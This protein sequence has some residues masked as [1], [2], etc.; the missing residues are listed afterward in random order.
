MWYI[1]NNIKPRPC[2]TPDHQIHTI[3]IHKNQFCNYKIYNVLLQKKSQ[4]HCFGATTTNSILN[5]QFVKIENTKLITPA[6]SI[7]YLEKSHL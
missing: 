4:F 7:L 2:H 1:C 6:F 3:K 5:P